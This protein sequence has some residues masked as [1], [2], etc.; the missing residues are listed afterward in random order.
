MVK[1]SVQTTANPEGLLIHDEAQNL[2]CL[3]LKHDEFEQLL[4]K[5][6]AHWAENLLMIKKTGWQNPGAD[7]SVAREGSGRTQRNDEQV[8]G[9]VAEVINLALYQMEVDDFE[10]AME[11]LSYCI[12]HI[13]KMN[14]VSQEEFASIFESMLIKEDF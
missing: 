3:D 8:Y 13:A 14:A 6:E 10:V 11:A 4:H 7:E 1:G 5:D 2:I 9:R 12:L